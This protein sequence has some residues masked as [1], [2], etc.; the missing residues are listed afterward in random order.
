MFVMRPIRIFLPAAVAACLL[1]LG[2]CVYFNTFFNAEKAYNQALSMREKRL[3]KNPDDTVVVTE[4]EKDSLQRAI[5]KCSKLLELYPDRLD[6]A[7]K[8][9]FL[10]AESYSLMEE[11][12]LAIEKYE[13]LER[14]YPKAPQNGLA[15][16]HRAKALYAEGQGFKAQAAVDDILKGNPTGEILREALLLEARMQIGGDSSSAGL[17]YYEKLLQEK[18]LGDETRANLQWEAARLAFNL[19]EWERARGHALAP[20]IEALPDRLQFRNRKLALFCLDEEKDY[21][22]GIGEAEWMFGKKA[23]SS[24]RPE[25]KLLMARGYESLEDWKTAQG[26]YREVPVLSPKTPVSAESYYR[27]GN[28]FLEA[29]HR[30]DSAKVYFDSAAA[31][32]QSFEFGALGAQKSKALARIA[33]LRK[34]KP[35]SSQPHYENFMIAETFLFS[36]SNADSALARLDKIVQSPNLD[37]TYTVRAAYARAYIQAEMKKDTVKGDSLY[38]YVM[39]KFPNTE[40][41]KQS[42]KNLG[43]KPTIQTDEDKAHLLFLAAEKRRFDSADVAGD[44]IPAYREVYRQYPRTNQAAQALFVIAFLRED[45]AHREPPVQGSLDSAKVAYHR[46][47]TEFPQTAY[48]HI[49]S[50]K[51]EKVNLPYESTMFKSPENSRPLLSSDARP[52]ADTESNARRGV[53]L[54]S[55]FENSDQY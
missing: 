45:L 32:G 7:P 34:D 16:I 24:F 39:E 20:E 14:Y 54:E 13:E 11:Y 51:M 27:L 46:L 19:G 23:F 55:K 5:D 37:S 12:A 21:K 49:A 48:G 40:W 10:M 1:L 31:A 17:A 44:V 33:E 2:G 30:E 25:L 47:S 8:A 9:L 3:A 42:E 43:L 41:A 26:L 28:H 29:F 22:K 50:Q 36:L 6:Y 35:D 38:R 18:G 15:E 53:C 52:E 4:A